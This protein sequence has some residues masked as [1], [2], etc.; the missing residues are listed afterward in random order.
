MK[1]KSLTPA[2]GGDD[3]T[4]GNVSKKCKLEAFKLQ[5]KSVTIH[6]NGLILK[7]IEAPCEAFVETLILEI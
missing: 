2:S 5:E 4:E 7:S 3:L 1:I 6:T